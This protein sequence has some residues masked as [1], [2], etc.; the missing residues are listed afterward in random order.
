MA[1]KPDI[2]DRLKSLKLKVTPQRV[3]IY[4]ALSKVGDH[5][6]AEQ[7]IRYLNDCHPNIA[8]GTVY[9]TLDTFV[10]KGLLVKV[11]TEKDV[12]RYDA[13]LTRHHHIYYTDSNVIRDY[14]DETLDALLKKYFKSKALPG[15]DITD[16]KIQIIGTFN[17]QRFKRPGAAGGRVPILRKPA[18]KQS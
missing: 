11:L 7:I 12:M 9:S 8:V 5:P 3:A 17:K 14:N 4:E 16:I 1:N 10:K 13:I 15:L 2:R 18:E 6:T